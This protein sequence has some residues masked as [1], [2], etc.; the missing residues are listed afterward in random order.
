MRAHSICT[1]LVIAIIVIVSMF[2]L[3]LAVEIHAV[4]EA[5][6][7]CVDGL[8]T[9]T[10]PERIEGNLRGL[11]AF[12]EDDIFA[13]N[14][15]GIVYH[16]DGSTW[17]ELY[18]SPSKYYV[19]DIWGTSNTN[20]YFCLNEDLSPVNSTI[21]HFDGSEW[22]E[23]D[24]PFFLIRSYE[25]VFGFYE[26]DIY[27]VGQYDTYENL[28]FH[29]VPGD[30]LTWELVDISSLGIEMH[31]T[32][33]WGSSGDDVF[34]TGE[35]GEII[36]WDGA[37]WELMDSGVTECIYGIWGSG[38]KDVFAILSDKIIHYDGKQQGGWTEMSIPSSTSLKW[39][40]GTSSNDVIAGG[41]QSMMLHYDGN[42]WTEI[43]SYVW[44][45]DVFMFSTDFALFTGPYGKFYKYTGSAVE[46]CD[47][48]DYGFTRSLST[49]T[50]TPTGTF[51]ASGID[52]YVSR[53]DGAGWVDVTQSPTYWV[54]DIIAFADDD[55]CVFT[56]DEAFHFDGVSWES[57]GSSEMGCTKA[58]GS[59][60]D[61]LY[62][63][64]DS[65]IYHFDGD[66]W[67]RVWYQP[68]ISYNETEWRCEY[69]HDIWG[70]SNSD[71]YAVGRFREYRWVGSGY[72][73]YQ[74]PL[75]VHF[76]GTDWT[77]Q[78][79]GVDC[80]NWI[81][82][83]YDQEL[84]RVWGSSADD[85]WAAGRMRSMVDGCKVL[86]FDGS[87][88][89]EI[90]APAYNYSA[91]WGT[92]A[93]SDVYFLLGAIGTVQHYDGDLWDEVD[94]TDVEI[95]DIWGM[96]DTGT[97]AEMPPQRFALS[98]N[99]PNPFNPA[100][101][102]SFSLSERGHASLVIYDV[103][104]RLVRVLADNV[105]EAGPHEVTWDGRDHEG[106]AIASGVY[107]YRLETGVYTETR[108]MVLLR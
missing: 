59:S 68:C 77:Y 38:S 60:S 70:T 76:D 91:I 105:M 90:E 78:E 48:T 104:G 2:G 95:G 39:I 62:T 103:A 46:R 64:D 8:W 98:Q 100:T 97:P 82:W 24:M 51:Y 102:V 101:T 12:G 10:A 37:Q 50:S 52:G 106:R 28:I 45:G 9:Q 35:D 20:L 32:D 7:R 21:L 72:E 47:L 27:V 92:A 80:P 84:R 108:K 36:H 14:D 19:T 18:Q 65:S 66:D 42:V 22:T 88:W 34:I 93:G 11:W 94:L 85:I 61:D 43:P 99:H 74:C 4:G 44:F 89:S 96:D 6:Y 73:L 5:A 41:W 15:N 53:F 54:Y 31:C 75:I 67:T 3:S 29:S 69:V 25:A 81:P 57:M 55:I 17:S 33:V 30:S 16:Y 71:I 79:T 26:D 87:S 49:V 107:F 83:G 40:T 56:D 23:F 1:G 63:V 13:G 86:H 58:W